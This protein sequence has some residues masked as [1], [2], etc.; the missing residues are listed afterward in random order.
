[1]TFV[2]DQ[3]AWN[4]GKKTGIVTTG[5]FSKGSSPWNK[6]KSTPEEVKAK[7]SASKMGQLKGVP[8]TE[9]VKKKISIANNRGLTTKNKLER[10]R[11]YR[12]LVPIIFARD[13]YTCQICD[14][15]NGILHV[16]HIKSW[17]KYPELQFDLDNCRTLCRPCH[18]YVTFKRKIPNN[19][20][21]GLK[22][23][24]T[25]RMRG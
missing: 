15:Y 22:L 1:M 3:T 2:K 4:K 5:C 9:E 12:E 7:I 6:G 21:W 14:Q 10:C 16:D 23:N 11:F 24:A 13:N 19:S 8:R 20:A 17:S 25:A 18:Y